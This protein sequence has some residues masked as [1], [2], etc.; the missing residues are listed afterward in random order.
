MKKGGEY[1]P[2]VSSSSVLT[3]V[4]DVEWEAVGDEVFMRS[5]SGTVHLLNASAS[6]LWEGLNGQATI[7]DLA[8]ALHAKYPSVTL[9]T[10]VADVIEMA[11]EFLDKEVA[12]LLTRE[13]G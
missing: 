12:L 10:I 1:M 11:T 13:E 5:P 4:E 8:E 7:A 3:R 9:E 2:Q 6:R